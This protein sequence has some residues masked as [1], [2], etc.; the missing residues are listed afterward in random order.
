M[1]MKTEKTSSFSKTYYDEPRDEMVCFV[2]ISAKRL[3]DVG[4]GQGAFGG[5]LLKTHSQLQIWGIEPFADAAEVAQQRLAKVIN[6]TVENALES[7][8]EHYF[9]CVIFNDSLY[10]RFAVLASPLDA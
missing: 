2:P 5:N 3:L 7:L 4:C 10:E 6:T 9:D 8:P 1:K